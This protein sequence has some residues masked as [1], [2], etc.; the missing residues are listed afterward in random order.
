[1]QKVYFISGLGADHRAFHFLNLAFC[2]PVFIDWIAA[3]KE[4]SLC[5]YAS[6]LR[7]Q[8]PEEHPIVVGLSLGGMITTEM[9]KKD[10]AIQAIIL[11][12]TKTYL[13]FPYYL[14]FF[15]YVPIHKAL[16]G[17]AMK[18][19]QSLYSYVFGIKEPE[20]RKL[21]QQIIADADIGFVKWAISAILRWNNT[22][23]PSNVTHIHG[24]HD[25]LLRVKYV[26]PDVTIAG[27]SHII[28]FD[29]S[30]EIS[31]LLQQ[32]IEKNISPA[33]AKIE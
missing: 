8:I 26:H 28:T 12:S 1:M 29:K 3:K 4:E 2:E 16:P 27:G 5:D 13:E 23:I 17:V 10:P 9:A 24:T 21:L 18:K 15:K 33:K 22:T 6:R 7:Q 32:L 19:M 25:K 11:A 14:R 20:K 30:E 31:Q